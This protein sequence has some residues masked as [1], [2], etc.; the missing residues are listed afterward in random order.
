MRWCALRRRERTHLCAMFIKPGR[1]RWEAAA[2]KSED[3][4]GVEEIGR[5]EE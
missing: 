1:G 5:E 4:L 3:D 2:C